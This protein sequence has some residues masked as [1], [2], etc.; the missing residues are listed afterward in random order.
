MAA[1]LSGDDFAV[2]LPGTSLNDAEI[3]AMRLR[4]SAADPPQDDAES[5]PA[6]TI[7]VGL[8]ML[9]A[10]DLS[11]DDA[12]S[13]AD[14]ALRRAK[15]DGGNRVATNAAPSALGASLLSQDARRPG[16]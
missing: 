2:L 16:E 10:A 13:R 12:L 15:Q 5:P 4:Q 11:P 3:F 14:A 6:L 9:R 7:S 8:T 1:R